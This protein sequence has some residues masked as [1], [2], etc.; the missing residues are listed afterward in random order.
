MKKLEF[1]EKIDVNKSIKILN[2]LSKYDNAQSIVIVN[3]FIIAVEA[4]EGTDEVLRRAAIVR[5]KA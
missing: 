1:N 3:G 4:A 2:N 5:K